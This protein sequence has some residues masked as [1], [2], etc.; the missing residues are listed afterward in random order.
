M[1]VDGDV[2]V[3]EAARARGRREAATD[4]VSAALGDA[5]QLFHVDVQQVA[6]GGVLVAQLLPAHA[7][8]AVE[9][10]ETEAAEHGVGG[11]AGDPERP[12][13]AV[14]PEPLAAAHRADALL[15]R[16]CG[17]A[18]IRARSGGAVLES[19]RALL[20]VAAPPLADRRTRNP[21]APRNLRLRP[22]GLD[23]QN[24]LQ[25]GGRSQTRVR[26]C[27]ERLLSCYWCVLHTHTAA[28]GAPHL[29]QLTWELQLG[30]VI[31]GR[32]WRDAVAQVGSE[33]G[34]HR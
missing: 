4:A 3:V 33:L 25:P 15:E 21:E 19:G 2:E 31:V 14:R 27:H 6:G 16:G 22:A 24:H 8:Q 18:R 20:V 5:A 28:G 7:V 10:V 9:A 30:T 34:R 17:A 1:V 32:P 13:D 26:M 29:Q 23:L 12:G 11:G